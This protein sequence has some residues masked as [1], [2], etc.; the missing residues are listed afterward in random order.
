MRQGRT[1]WSFVFDD[2]DVVR[3]SEAPEIEVHVVKSTAKMGGIAELGVPATAPAVANAFFTA[4]G[5]RIRRL[6]LNPAAVLAAL[7]KV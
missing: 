1:R 4:T 3:M 2:Y 6:P 7:A 5:V